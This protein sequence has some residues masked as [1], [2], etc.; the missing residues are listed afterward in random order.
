MC[1]LRK[2]PYG[3]FSEFVRGKKITYNVFVCHGVTRNKIFIHL[4]LSR[5]ITGDIWFEANVLCNVYVCHDI[6]RD[7]N[8]IHLDLS[9]FITGDIWFETNVLST[10]PIG[11]GI[12]TQTVIL[13]I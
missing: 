1:L 13:C 6:T 2:I 10:M 11:T 5:L 7:K 12:A 9:R 4:D 8:F 3:E